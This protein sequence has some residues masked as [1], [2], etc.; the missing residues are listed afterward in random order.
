MLRKPLRQL[1]EDQM[2]RNGLTIVEC[3]LEPVLRL[4]GLPPHHKDPFDRLIVSQALTENWPVVSHDPLISQ[5][6]VR[7]IW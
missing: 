4:E 6:P 7:V 1:I 3:G 2:L 5:Y